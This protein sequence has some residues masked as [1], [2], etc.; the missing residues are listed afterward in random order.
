MDHTK[1]REA[2]LEKSDHG[3]LQ[4]W[5]KV[6]QR[7]IQVHWEAAAKHYLGGGLEKGTPSLVHLRV[8]QRR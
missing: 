5:K 3:N 8:L 2:N 6:Q 7:A 4:I 1:D